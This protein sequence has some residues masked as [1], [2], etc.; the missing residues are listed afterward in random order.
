MRLHKALEAATNAAIIVA[1][2]AFVFTGVHVWRLSAAQPQTLGNVPQYK[3]GDVLDNVPSIDFGKADRALVLFVNSACH[4]CSE[5]MPFYRALLAARNRS[6]SNVRVAALAREDL[7]TLRDYLHEKQLAPDQSLAIPIDSPAKLSLT[8][9]LLLVGRD[10]VIKKLW[11]GALTASGEQEVLSA[12]GA[13]APTTIGRNSRKTTLLS[14]NAT[15][16]LF[17]APSAQRLPRHAAVMLK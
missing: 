7:A 13:S 12:V 3:V 4:Y 16:P 9:T 10:M 11:L 14:Q 15:P 17:G 2:A 1:A 8:P 6:N 5:S